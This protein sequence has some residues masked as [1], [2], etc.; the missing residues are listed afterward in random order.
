MPLTVVLA[1]VVAVIGLFLT[2]ESAFE[3]LAAFGF[4]AKSTGNRLTEKRSEA[5]IGARSVGSTSSAGGEGVEGIRDQDSV[6]PT[7]EKPAVFTSALLLSTL[8]CLLVLAKFLL[9]VFMALAL[10]N[11]SSVND[12]AQRL[13]NPAPVL[14]QRVSEEEILPQNI[15][16]WLPDVF[17]ALEKPVL[18]DL[19]DVE[20]CVDVDVF[21]SAAEGP[22]KASFIVVPETAD[23]F[24]LLYISLIFDLIFCTG[25]FVYTVLQLEVVKARMNTL[26]T[27]CL[28]EWSTVVQAVWLLPSVILTI[29]V[30][31]QSGSDIFK[32]GT[33][34][35]WVEDIGQGHTLR[36]QATA[37][38]IQEVT[39]KQYQVLADASSATTSEWCADSQIAYDK[40]LTETSELFDTLSPSYCNKT[41]SFDDSRDCIISNCEEEIVL[42]SLEWFDDGY[43]TVE[44]ELGTLVTIDAVV[45][46]VQLAVFVATLSMVKWRQRQIRKENER[47]VLP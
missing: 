38:L 6:A 14:P 8:T 31:A 33:H 1:L 13:L 12:N 46:L 9:M 27:D 35:G 18:D 2:A 16:A 44:S 20:D 22:F 39:A 34:A 23:V 5:T 25:A 24:D 3:V 37:P 29:M 7:K 42:S 4:R 11:M 28:E 17:T 32:F 43:V 26:V 19:C 41:W 30:L 15:S 36:V 21:T 47:Q 40:V 45:T 10:L